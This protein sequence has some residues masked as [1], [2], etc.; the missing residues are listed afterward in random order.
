MKY[1]TLGPTELKISTVCLGTMTWGQQNSEADAH[2]QMDQALAAGINFIDTAEMYPVPPTAETQGLTERYIGSWLQRRGRRQ[3]WILATKI[4]GPRQQPW[5]R[6]G[7]DLDRASVFAA[8]ESSLQRLQTDSIDLYQVH[9]PARRVN[10]FGQLGYPLSGGDR[11]VPIEETLQALG[12]LVRMGKVRHIGISNETAWGAAEYLR[13]ARD[14]GLPR[15]VSIQN[16]YSLLNRSFEIALAEFTDREQLGLL[17]YSPMAFG[18]LSGKYLGG[19]KPAG[20]RL[21]LYQ[22]FR[23]Y[24][25]ASAQAAIA[26][27]AALARQHGIEPAAMALAF[28]M[29]Q[30]FVHSTIIGATTLEQLRQ[31]IDC[32]DLHLSPSLRQGIEQI[33]AR[34]TIP[35]P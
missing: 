29:E 17:A 32:V 27:Y 11:G 7:P 1:R 30:P 20:A 10:S 5:I 35:A 16:P 23:R 3:D 28:V 25:G 9:W 14:A 2:A 22:R 6:N 24:Q 4:V 26:A 34:Y 18:A 33:H 31:N 15:V 19:R 21:T 8:C 12:E 13:L